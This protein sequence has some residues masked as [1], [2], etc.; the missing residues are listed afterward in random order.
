MTRAGRLP[1]LAALGL[2]AL[3]LAGCGPARGPEASELRNLSWLMAVPETA[4]AR[5]AR[6]FRTTC[7]DTRADGAA[8][9][10]AL[11]LT[12]YVELPAAGGGARRFVVDD[13][14]PAVLVAETRAGRSCAVVARAR[15]GQAARAAR[16]AAA[17]P[18]AREV[19]ARRLAA[20]AERAWRLPDGALVATHRHREPVRDDLFAIQYLRPLGSGAGA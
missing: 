3:G 10:A 11:A 7:L 4:P 13:M 5:L 17:L 12:D 18:G 8:I 16:L 6:A 14:R 15:T 2:G 20:S 1:L 19:D 9:A